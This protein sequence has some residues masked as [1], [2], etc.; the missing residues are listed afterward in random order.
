MRHNGSFTDEESR[1]I[2]DVVRYKVRQLQRG[3]HCCPDE[4]GDLEQDI[5]SRILPILPRFDPTRSGFRT[6]LNRTIDSA[7]VDLRR[8][9]GTKKR[10][11]G[12]NVVSLQTLIP[13]ATD[14]Q[15]YE[16]ASLIA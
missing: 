1:Q 11:T 13:S 5:V 12:R 16:L 10:G 7:S 15:A 4:A 6:F 2:M 14:G 8:K 3:A 9:T